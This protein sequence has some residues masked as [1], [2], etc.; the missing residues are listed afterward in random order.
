MVRI[1]RR[2]DKPTTRRRR[3]QL[4]QQ[5]ILGQRLSRISL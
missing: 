5:Q 2:I 1:R 3:Q 4:Q